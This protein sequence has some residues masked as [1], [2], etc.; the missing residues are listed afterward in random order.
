MLL[1]VSEISFE[2][3][4]MSLFPLSELTPQFCK[5]PDGEKVRVSSYCT[6]NLQV[7]VLSVGLIKHFTMCYGIT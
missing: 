2:K 5:T 6:L 1:L 3:R 4:A 7:M